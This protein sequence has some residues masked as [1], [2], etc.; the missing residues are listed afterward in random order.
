[1]GLIYKSV[2]SKGRKERE[3][4][5][6]LEGVN[7]ETMGQ[8]A[9]NTETFNIAIDTL[10]MINIYN[11][12]ATKIIKVCDDLDEDNIRGDTPKLD[13]IEDIEE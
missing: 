1:M 5:Y 6:N 11:W 10:Q 2:S 8:F 3:Y 4:T 13:F 9:D 12:D 7:F